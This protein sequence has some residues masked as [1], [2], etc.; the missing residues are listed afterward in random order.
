MKRIVLFLPNWVGDAIQA[1]PLLA[2]LRQLYGPDAVLIGLGRQ[3]V[4]EVLAGHPLLATLLRKPR[5]GGKLRQL[6]HTIRL[7]R[8]WQPDATL[9]LTNDLPSA[10]ASR[11][12]GVP[13]RVGYARRGRGPLLTDKLL[14]PR[15]GKRFLPIPAVDYYLGLARRLGWSG[16]PPPLSLAVEIADRANADAVLGAFPDPLRPLAV[17]AN[18]GA[19]GP[20]KLWTEEGMVAL[21]RALT[22]RGCNVV[23]IGGPD[24][25]AATRRMAKAASRREVLAAGAIRNV[26][27]GLSK[28]LVQ[29]ARL[30]VSTDSGP[31]HMGPAF[32]VP[33]VSLFGPTDPAWTDLKTPL[34]RWVRLALECQPCQARSCPLGHHRCMRELGL[35]PVLAAAEAQLEQSPLCSDHCDLGPSHLPLE[36][37]GRAKRGRG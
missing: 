28:A 8:E 29:R 1:T 17:L 6:R 2:A 3:P 33:T 15:D 7:L 23:L 16:E 36:G 27:L 37:G 13:R 4:L 10:L 9:L 5:G 22:E 25:L 31:R 26:S 34:D 11:L 24:E 35:A 19:F 30:L 20:A 21:A 18:S 14:P 32:G 12:A